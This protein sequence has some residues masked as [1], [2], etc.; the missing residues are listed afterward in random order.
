MLERKLYKLPKSRITPTD[1]L[2][3][4]SIVIY[5]HSDKSTSSERIHVPPA[6]GELNTI[7]YRKGVPRKNR[8]MY[9]GEAF[10]L[11][12]QRVLVY[13]QAKEQG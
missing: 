11:T 13:E 8:F 1:V 3:E 4:K 9:I 6:T 7:V 5:I 12:G 10:S 2:P